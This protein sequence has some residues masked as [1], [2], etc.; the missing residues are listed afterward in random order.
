MIKVDRYRVENGKVIKPAESWFRRAKKQTAKAETEGETHKVTALYKDEQVK[1]VL[2]KLFVDK[3]AYCETHL[4]A[5]D[6]DVEHY[7]PR[8][9]VAERPD[10]P[11]YYWLAYKWENLYPS[12]TFCNQRRKDQP[13]YNDPRMMPA[14]G[15][16]DSFP[17]KNEIHRAMKPGDDLSMESPLLLDPCN[18]EPEMH[19]TYD[20]HGQVQPLRPDDDMALETIRICHLRRRRLRDNRARNIIRVCKLIRTIQLARD[21]GDGEVEQQLTQ[22]LEEEF[23]ASSSEYAGA[24]RAVER[25]PEAFLSHMQ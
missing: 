24:A 14:A 23:T 13:R 19:L 25:D 9:R 11:G 7:R 4:V 18:D 16:L 5:G 8:G 2:E 1:M 6:W 3:C 22:L 12:C 20:I 10:H 15:K 17:I 21:T